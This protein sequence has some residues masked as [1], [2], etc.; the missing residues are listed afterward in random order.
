ML[1]N[2]DRIARFVKDVNSPGKNFSGPGEKQFF[3][4]KEAAYSGA[5]GGGK[6][7]R[8]K[9]AIYAGETE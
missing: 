5:L 6:Q 4:Y 2:D 8:G 9:A 3:P 7:D 1:I